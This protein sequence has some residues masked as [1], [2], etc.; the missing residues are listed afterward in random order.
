MW[1]VF[2]GIR[3]LLGCSNSST[4]LLGSKTFGRVDTKCTEST[5]LTN[6]V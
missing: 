4:I 2:R 6:S 1:L 5:I 3:D